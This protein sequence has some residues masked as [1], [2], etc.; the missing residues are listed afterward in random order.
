MDHGDRL[1]RLPLAAM[2][3]AALTGAGATDPPLDPRLQPPP[4]PEFE[5]LPPAAKDKIINYVRHLLQVDTGSLTG[6]PD[7]DRLTGSLD[8]RYCLLYTSRCV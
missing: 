6:T 5:E 7:L 1:E 4:T 2:F 8:P 3:G